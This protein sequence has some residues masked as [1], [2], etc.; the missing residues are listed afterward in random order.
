MMERKKGEA[1]MRGFCNAAGIWC[2]KDLKLDQKIY[3][4][5]KRERFDELLKAKEIFL[6]QPI[7]WNDPWETPARFIN[8]IG[9]LENEEAE[10]YLEYQ[11]KYFTKFLYGICFTKNYDTDSMWRQYEGEEKGKIGDY[12]CVETTIK[13]FFDSIKDAKGIAEV[14]AGPISYVDIKGGI[15]I[16]DNT[17][18]KNYPTHWYMAFVK[19]ISFEHEGEVRVLFSGNHELVDGGTKI[20]IKPDE[21]IQKIY[22]HPNC[23]EAVVNEIK[24]KYKE[25]NVIVE[26]SELYNIPDIKIEDIK[27]L[28]DK[29]SN[30]GNNIMPESAMFY[31]SCK[32]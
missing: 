13:H 19:R 4:F 9:E 28:G 20:T 26:R 8:N 7:K 10:Y 5:F 17:E 18:C 6:C 27:K 15:E 1:D 12:I 24:D 3:H 21:F 25:L 32:L 23:E 14:F 16:F 11:F 2:H 29:L 31:C 22:L 30:D